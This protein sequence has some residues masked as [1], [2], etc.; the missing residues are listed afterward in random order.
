MTSSPSRHALAAVVAAVA[1]AAAAACSQS[2]KMVR[3]WSDPA[4]T[5]GSVKSVFVVGVSESPVIRKSYED[6]FVL[7]LQSKSLKVSPGYELIPDIQQVDKEAVAEQL[8]KL[9]VTHVLVTRVVERREVEQYHPPSY[10]SVGVGYGGYP[11]YYGGWG[12]YMSVGYTTMASPGYTT[13]HTVVS[14]ESN[15]YDLQTEK[16]VW[17]GLSEGYPN[18]N[19]TDSFRPYIHQLIYDMKAKKVI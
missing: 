12:S 19:P 14:V 16:M 3:S 8:E 11:G 13:V 17:T 18:D 6:T 5:E 7:S 15:L 4:L 1:L 9:G 2:M 10:V